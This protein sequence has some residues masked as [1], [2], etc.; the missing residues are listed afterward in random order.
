MRNFAGLALTVSAMFLLLVAVLL[1]SGALFYMSTAVIATMGASRIQAYLSVRGLHFERTAPEKVKAGEM[2]TIQITV[3]SDRRIRRPLITVADNLPPRM[4]YNEL[5]AS[6]PIAPAFDIPIQTQFQFR[7]LRRGRYRWSGLTVVGTDALGLVSTSKTYDTTPVEMLVVP[8]PMPLTVD[9]VNASGWGTAESEHGQSRGSGIEP[10]GVREYSTGDA[11]RYVHWRSSAKAGQL[12]VKEFETG[13]HATVGLVIQQ[14]EGSVAGVGV[15][16]TLE[17]MIANAAF[18]SEQLLRMGAEVT[19]PGVEMERSRTFGPRERQAEIT[20]ALAGI[21]AD[22][23]D[24]VAKQLLDAKN[25]LPPGGVVYVFVSMAD[26]A[27]PT[28]VT[29]LVGSGM[30]VIALVYD[31]SNYPVSKRHGV[32]ASAAD[33]AYIETLRHAGAMTWLVPKPEVIV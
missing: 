25:D 12:L 4:V 8:N 6:L 9:V 27:L 7:P 19:V 32:F 14:S 24:S 20:A 31:P 17:Q 2:V 1:N 23:I 26:K 21:E 3:W 30:R 18:L 28:A 5:S 33:D 13:S 10:R 15:D 11:L 22:N 29:T 16:T